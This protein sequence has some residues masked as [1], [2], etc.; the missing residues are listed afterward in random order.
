MKNNKLVTVNC[1]MEERNETISG[2]AFLGA[3]KKETG[4][5]VFVAGEMDDEVIQD[6]IA[7]SMASVFRLGRQTNLDPVKCFEIIMEALPKAVALQLK[8]IKESDVKRWDKDFIKIATEV[9][10]DMVSDK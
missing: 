8:M 2:S 3:I 6:L 4:H 9:A 1:Q 10:M 5:H 7:H